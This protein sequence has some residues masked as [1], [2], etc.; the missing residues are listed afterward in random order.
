MPPEI[1][2]IAELYRRQRAGEAIVRAAA[3]PARA[4]VTP[5]EGESVLDAVGRLFPHGMHVGNN[6][7]HAMAV[8]QQAE[9]S[10]VKGDARGANPARQPQ[11][12]GHN[13]RGGKKQ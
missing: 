12:K 10:R 8:R 1:I 5:Q 3:E 7:F 2:P 4:P 9:R 6:S 13:G 11:I